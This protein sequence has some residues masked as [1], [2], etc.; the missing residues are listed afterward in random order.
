MRKMSY[1]AAVSLDGFIAGPDEEIDWL[2]WSDEAGPLLKE[3]WA[4]VDTIL[5]GRKTWEFAVRS[6]GGGGGKSTNIRTYVFSRTMTEAPD[7]AELVREDAAGFVRALK[8]Q[9]GGAMFLMGGGE[10]AA[11][12]VEAGLVDEI[13]LNV[14]PMLLGRGLRMFGDIARRV[15][16]ELTYQRTLANGCVLVRY[17]AAATPSA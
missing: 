10:L 8:A 3:A 17:K 15:P 5:M 13:S 12:L 14:H 2:T 7:G 9:E 1:S 6:G 11:A 4:G 16:L